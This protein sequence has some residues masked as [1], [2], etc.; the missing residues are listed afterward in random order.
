MLGFP[1]EIWT[2][3]TEF[4]RFVSIHPI[5]HILHSITVWWFES[6]HLD[7]ISFWMLIVLAPNLRFIPELALVP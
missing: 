1:I 3:W 2:E 7:F 6:F 4:D 5:E